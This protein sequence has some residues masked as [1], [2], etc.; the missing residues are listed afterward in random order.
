MENFLELIEKNEAIFK[1]Q[2]ADRQLT[3][4]RAG[5]KRAYERYS[6]TY[7]KIDKV[8]WT[9]TLVGLSPIR[10]TFDFKRDGQDRIISGKFSQQVSQ[11]YLERIEKEDGI[12]LGDQ[13]SAKIEIG[14]IRKPDGT[15][16]EVYT[17]VDLELI[18][19]L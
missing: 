5:I 16:S 1:T 19:M 6:N 15:I 17:V 4:D 13:F 18:K 12:T 7:V 9:G 3:F 14:T 2:L 10:R 11:D 8:E